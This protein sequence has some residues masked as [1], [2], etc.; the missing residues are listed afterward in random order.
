[1][2][3]LEVAGVMGISAALGLGLGIAAE[4]REDQLAASNLA[5]AQA[6]LD[7]YTNPAQ[8]DAVTKETEDCLRREWTP[9]SRFRT[10]RLE[11]LNVVEGSPVAFVRAFI[12]HER[13]EANGLNLTFPACGAVV[14]ALV[15][16]L[17]SGYIVGNESSPYKPLDTRL[18]QPQDEKDLNRLLRAAEPV[19]SLV[20]QRASQA[21]PVA[22]KFH[23]DPGA[24]TYVGLREGSP[25]AF[26]SYNL[27]EIVAD[28]P[29]QADEAQAQE[30]DSYAVITSLVIDSLPDKRGQNKLLAGLEATAIKNGIQTLSATVTAD[31][32]LLRALLERSQYALVDRQSMAGPEGKLVDAILYTKD[33][34]A[35]E[36]A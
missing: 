6:C 4:A 10:V 1:M 16:L 33:L 12:E 18:Y 13:D 8:P 19:T 3:N 29:V 26:A 30:P 17:L 14:G 5:T 22:R 2:R 21:P 9:D 15:G 28:A 36:V 34:S 23:A 31:Q 35:P 24:T 20:S 27:K 32:E 7:A 25:V 11:D